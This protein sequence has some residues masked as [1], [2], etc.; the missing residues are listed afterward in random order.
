[1]QSGQM[2]VGNARGYPKVEQMRSASLGSA[3]ALLANIRLG[4]KGLKGKNTLAYCVVVKVQKD[5]KHLN[6]NGIQL[7]GIC[8]KLH[9]I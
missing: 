4:W 9:T 1:L 2:F 3:L 5:L 7:I 6:R 8:G